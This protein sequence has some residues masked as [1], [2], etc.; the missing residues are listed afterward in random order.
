MK[1]FLKFLV[2]GFITIFIL[3]TSIFFIYKGT[4]VNNLTKKEALSNK[5]WSEVYET[6]TERIELLKNISEVQKEKSSS[7]H[8]AIIN[9]YKVRDE[10][11]NECALDFVKIESDVNES[12]LDLIKSDS[13]ISKESALKIRQYDDRIN[14]QVKDY[15]ELTK[16]YNKYIS[17]FPNFFI[18]KQNNFKRKKLFTISYGERNEDPIQKSKELPEWAK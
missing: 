15:N 18:A 14:E 5:K 3:I 4:V 2:I 7:L 6:T 10:Y 13:L 12:I 9:N 17:V 1:N 16:D 8:I 11:K